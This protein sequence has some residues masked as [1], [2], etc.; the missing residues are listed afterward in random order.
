MD[1]LA[2][3]LDP[4]LEQRIKYHE[5]L[6]ELLAYTNNQPL[7][8]QDTE[9]VQQRLARVHEFQP[10]A[11]GQ[12]IIASGPVYLPD[13]EELISNQPT[14]VLQNK[15]VFYMRTWLGR[16]AV[17]ESFNLYYEVDINKVNEP[18]ESRYLPVR[19]S[20]IIHQDHEAAPDWPL[21]RRELGEAYVERLQ[22]FQR[23]AA[24]NRSEALEYL[25]SLH[26]DREID[27][28]VR[29]ERAKIFVQSLRIDGWK[30]AAFVCNDP[31]VT[32]SQESSA[33]PAIAVIGVP[34]EIE[35]NDLD[36]ES[37]L[38]VRTKKGHVK[39]KCGLAGLDFCYIDELR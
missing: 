35:V 1:E 25:S 37:Y 21:L 15:R 11:Y 26:Q 12:S 8:Q 24:S 5:A 16:N 39:L 4:T 20:E 27:D 2:E 31:T 14:E 32:L 6:D 33:N 13:G 22:A 10:F 3:P 17:H 30:Q 19:G 34:I 7:E 18:V 9:I 29:F 36:R 23:L 28:L 38:I